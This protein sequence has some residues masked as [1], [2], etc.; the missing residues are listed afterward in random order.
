MFMKLKF[1]ALCQKKPTFFEFFLTYNWL[2]YSILFMV[3]P[4]DV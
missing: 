3:V 2:I 4:A 1:R